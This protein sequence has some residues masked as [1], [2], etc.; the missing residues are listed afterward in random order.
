MN[1][2]II[3]YGLGNVQSIKNALYSIGCTN[4][5]L[6]HKKTE[7]LN[8][9]GVILPGVGAFGHGM[10]ELAKRKLP[11]TLYEYVATGKPL[12]GICLGMQLM[13][14]SSEEFGLNNGLS[15]IQGAVKKF[16]DNLQGKLPHISWNKLKF[17]QDDVSASILSGIGEIPDM[18]F[19]H[20]YVCH[21]KDNTTILS[22]TE[23][24]GIEF[25]SSFQENNI[26]GC[27]FHPEK[28]AINGLKVM[29]NFVNIAKSF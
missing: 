14:E 1:I 15:L 13:F 18:Y 22:T 16:P 11:E 3:D 9:D 5:L 25:C 8:A 6:S 19:V 26:Y 21:P 27:Q 12:L 7:V 10:N 28:S 2:V 4:V 23:Y 17:K 24:G 20:S 29:K